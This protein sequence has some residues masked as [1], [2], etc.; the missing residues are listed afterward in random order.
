M[1]RSRTTRGPAGTFL[2]LL[3][4]LALVA[5]ACG[6][7]DGNGSSGGSGGTEVS[8]SDCPVDALEDADG[9][10]EITVWHAVLGLTADTVADEAVEREVRAAV[11]L[12]ERRS[13]KLAIKALITVAR[14]VP[15]ME[16][17]LARALA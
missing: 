3:G 8:A 17:A 15:A 4:A 1:I 9:P 6:G 16:T 2:A 10:V 14:D 7:S 11:R 5:A 12:V 13:V